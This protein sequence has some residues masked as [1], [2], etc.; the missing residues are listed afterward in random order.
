MEGIEIRVDD[1]TLTQVDMQAD[2]NGGCY[3]PTNADCA[4]TVCADPNT[5]QTGPWADD[6]GTPDPLC[7]ARL[8]VELTTNKQVTVIW[9]GR[10]LVDHFQLTNYP[11]HRGRLVL[12]GRTGGNAQNAHFDNLHLVTTAAIEATFDRITSGP[13]PNQFTFYIS[14]NPPSVVTNISQVILDGVVVTSSVVLTKNGNQNIVT[15]TQGPLFA[16]GSTHTVSATWRTSSGQTLSA[17][18]LQFTVAPYLVVPSSL[19]V[20][21]VDTTKPGFFVRPF[22]TAAGNPNRNFWTDEQLEGLHGANLIDFSSVSNATG[23]GEAAYNAA[24][25]FSNSDSTGYLSPGQF[26]NNY[27]WN[28]FGIPA[29]SLTNED[30]SSLAIS[31]YVYFPNS[32]TYYFGVNSDDGF[33]LTFG[34]N[35]HDMLGAGR[36]STLSFDGGRGIG[37]N[38]N[39]GAIYVTTP[40]YYGMRLMFYNGG[41]GS[42]LEFYT[43]QTP[44]TGV[45]NILVNDTSVPGA[46]MTYQMSTVAPPYVSF[47]EPPL[48]D[49]QVMLNADLTYEL[50]DSSTS[51]NAGSIV[52]KVNGV[53]RSP[54]ITHPSSTV[55]RIAQPHPA[56]Y[57]PPGTNTV[58]LSFSDSASAPYSYSYTFVVQSYAT[59]TLPPGL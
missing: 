7:W 40:G 30:N 10:T 38:Q 46:V 35:S 37:D 50:T 3:S 58:E 23:N 36:L 52:L 2:R 59:T 20:S 22:Q 4:A 13:N 15:Y 49:D 45:T 31:A 53:T 11:N 48:D 21:S 6:G 43:T 44:A 39:N 17:T 1:K 51:V 56:T 9:K 42:G 12:M 18:G 29:P 55:T 14:D 16:A 8:E 24:F 26:P 41:G 54:T 19:A 25:D 57:W 47:A 33:R 27:S 28:M 5:E 32:G 34:R